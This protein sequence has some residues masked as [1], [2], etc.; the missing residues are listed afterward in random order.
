MKEASPPC[1]DVGKPTAGRDRRRSR[2]VAIGNRACDWLPDR[3]EPHEEVG[4]DRRQ[5]RR[6]RMR[7]IRLLIARYR[8]RLR[9]WWLTSC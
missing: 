2:C 6:Q 1:R 8:L 7:L 9:R 4:A 3:T 5:D